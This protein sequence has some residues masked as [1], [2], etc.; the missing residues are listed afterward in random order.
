MTKEHREQLAKNAKQLFVKCKDSV[1]D[2]QIKF[3]KEVKKQDKISE[4]LIRNV[5]QQIVAIADQFIAQA[6]S[7]LDR[8]QS[9][10]LGEK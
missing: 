3:I 5:E 1:R 2:V 6:E 7:I 8:K 10:L 4:D 9:E